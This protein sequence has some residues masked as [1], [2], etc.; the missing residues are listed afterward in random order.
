MSKSIPTES[1]IY[2]LKFAS[3]SYYVGQAQNIATRYTT[4]LNDLLNNKHFNHRVQQQ[5]FT[6]GKPIL[7][8][9]ELCSISDLNAIEPKYIDLED[10]LCLNILSARPNQMRGENSPRAIYSKESLLPVVEY[11]ANNRRTPH[12]KIAELFSIDVGTIH[13]I[14]GGRGRLLEF[15]DTH[16]EL[17]AKII[18]TKAHN[19]RGINTVVLSNGTETVT[20]KTG[21]YMDFCRK[22]N[23]QSSNL[24]KVITGKRKH[25]QGWRLLAN[26]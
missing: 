23:I 24:S 13:D 16:P 11:I 12:Q 10:T 6:E 19:T 3:G 18:S 9:L 15:S 1:G 26:G 20:L 7:E 8:V 4:H 17:V 5:Y 21:E 25:T 2:K 22:N 14:S